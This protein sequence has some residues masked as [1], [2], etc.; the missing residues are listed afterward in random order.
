MIDWEEKNPQDQLVIEIIV[1]LRVT[2]GIQSPDTA[3]CK[4]Q[5]FFLI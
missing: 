5:F 2:F 1:S 3:N 4:N